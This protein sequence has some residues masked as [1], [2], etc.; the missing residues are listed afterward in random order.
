MSQ[1]NLLKKYFLLCFLLF[2]S[3]SQTFAQSKEDVKI[4]IG[5]QGVE[6]AVNKKIYQQFYVEAYAGLGG[7]YDA[8]D[9]FSYTLDVK[10]LVPYTKGIVKWNYVDQ[11]RK[12]NFVSLQGKYSFGDKDYL[13]LNRAL[14]TEVNWGIERHFTENFIFEAHVGIGHLKD[15][16][17]KKSLVLPTV[18]VSLKYRLFNFNK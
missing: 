10:N 13:D 17:V 16:D 8:V 7:G 1:T 4:G 11:D 14:L 3:A 12:R 15:F 18:G 6:L 2:G 5:L 9:G